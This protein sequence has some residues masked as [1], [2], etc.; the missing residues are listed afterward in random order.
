MTVLKDRGHPLVVN[1]LAASAK[2]SLSKLVAVL[3]WEALKAAGVIRPSK[4]SATAFAVAS[5]AGRKNVRSSMVGLL[6]FEISR[7]ENDIE[8]PLKLD[9]AISIGVLAKSLAL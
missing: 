7:S 9:K 4:S 5:I 6:S 2:S 1:V 8:K 3:T